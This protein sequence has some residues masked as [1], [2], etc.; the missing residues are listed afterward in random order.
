MK[1][2]K[3]DT[4][5]HNQKYNIYQTPYCLYCGEI[6]RVWD[7]VP[8]ILLAYRCTG[9]FIKIASCKNCNAL[10]SNLP[11][12]TLKSRKEHIYNRLIKKYKKVLDIPA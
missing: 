2:R 3:K 7:H 8:P 10:L 6:P 4:K 9:S 1:N 11:L 5:I 12:Y